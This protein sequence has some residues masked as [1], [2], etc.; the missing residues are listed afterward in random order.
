MGKYIARSFYGLS[1]FVFFLYFMRI[2]SVQSVSNGQ[3]IIDVMK[4]DTGLCSKFNFLYESNI[5]KICSTVVYSEKDLLNDSKFKDTFLC[6][7]FYD[8]VYKACHTSQPQE[9]N[10]T[11][12]FE[13]YIRKFFPGQ[14]EFCNSVGSI[15]FLYQKLKPFLSSEYFNEAC[16]A[17]CFE[18]GRKFVPLCAILSWSK[19]IDDY[20][21]KQN[22]QKQSPS[23]I[24]TPIK[25]NPDKDTKKVNVSVPHTLNKADKNKSDTV[26]N[27]TNS[28]TKL[29]NT[30]NTPAIISINDKPVEQSTE[31]IAQKKLQETATKS[32]DK[33]VK[34]NIG[35]GNLSTLNKTKVEAEVKDTENLEKPPTSNQRPDVNE[36]LEDSIPPNNDIDGNKNDANV[37]TI[38]DNIKTSTTSENKKYLVS[39]SFLDDDDDSMHPEDPNEVGNPP[40][41][42][43]EQ[44]QSVP[45]PS[46]Q[47]IVPHYHSIRTDE[48]SHFFTY[49]TVIS[50]ISIA[51]YIGYHNKQK[52]LAIVLE[53][54][55]SRS[56]RGRRRPSTANYR[57]LDC[58]LEEAVTSQCNAN[59]T[60]V[61]Y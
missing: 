51:T 27:Q 10:D 35:P 25:G 52:I 12:T 6:L 58:T 13:S 53:G 15:Q 20:T 4:N 32:D 38:N 42:T 2:S 61:I 47:D 3:N 56:S 24:S 30:D 21:N 43:A 22:Q 8:T 57:K 14:T 28:T 29:N 45:E 5:T 7:S 49:F 9:F 40:I 33:S 59:V 44:G 41:I 48:E 16:D 1:V 55:R 26:K 46:E 19:S 34:L 17:I 37:N 31:G 23:S 50:L 54:R 11:A 36:K 39:N 60:H 18:T